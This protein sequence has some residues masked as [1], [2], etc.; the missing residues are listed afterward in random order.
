MQ[1]PVL[2]SLLSFLFS[3]SLLGQQDLGLLLK[4][5]MPDWPTASLE[6]VGIKGDSLRQ[7]IRTIG[8][9]KPRDF[10][11]IVIIKDNKVVLEEYFNT[12]W[13]AT[14]HDIRSAGKSVTGMLMGIAIDKGLIKGVDQAIMDFF[15]KEKMSLDLTEKIG[16]IT[17]KDLLT[18]SSGLDAD[19]Y[20]INSKGNELYLL[21]SDDWIEF[22]L[23]LSMKFEPGTIYRYNSVS[24]M[25]AGAVIENAS[26]MSLSAFADKH[27][28]GPLGIEDYYWFAGPNKRVAGMGNIYITALDFAKL[29]ALIA[30]EGKWKGKQLI[31]QDW[32]QEML[33]KRFDIRDQDPFADGYGYLWYISSK[34]VSNKPYTYFFAS[35]NGGNKLYVIPELNLAVSIQSSAYRE[36]Y[37]HG[38]AE[39]IFQLLL[40][41]LE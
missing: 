35:G 14:V 36:G 3:F 40:Q 23:S 4:K 32:L 28:F 13:R 7:L 39:N 17:I 18:M 2:I 12:Y 21:A 5:P 24:A 33:V 1:K 34:E 29:G 11:G 9:T 41:S 15:P 25:L 38:R 37:G 31:K 22:S 20:D 30:N 16:D 10:R 26:G 19:A 6:E 27:L 8:N